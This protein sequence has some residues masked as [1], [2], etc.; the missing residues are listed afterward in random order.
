MDTRPKEEVL[1]VFENSLQDVPG[2][3][4][5]QESFRNRDYANALISNL[6]FLG[7][8]W[9]TNTIIWMALIATG[10]D[11]LFFRMKNDTVINI[12]DKGVFVFDPENQEK[13]ALIR[14]EELITF[15][16]TSEDIPS[17][18]MRYHD[19][20]GEKTVSRIAYNSP[21]IYRALDEKYP[22]KNLAVINHERIRLN[23]EKSTG[24]GYLSNFI[25]SLKKVFKR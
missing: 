18:V 13:G 5:L 21:K 8:G 19:E 25:S 14:D 16:I 22:D 9:L 4:V 6:L 12:Y 1:P 23:F 20:N 15:N 10:L 24:K 11:F 2:D 17:L 7:I 3:F